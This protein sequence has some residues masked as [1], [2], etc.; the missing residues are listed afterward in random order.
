MTSMEMAMAESV[1]NKLREDNRVQSATV[2]TNHRGPYVHC[3]ATD[4]YAKNDLRA[5]VVEDLPVWVE[6]EPP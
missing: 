2:A 3:T 5:N 4:R 1:A 6:V